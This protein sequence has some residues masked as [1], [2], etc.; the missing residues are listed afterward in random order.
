MMTPP[1]SSSENARQAP[2]RS[3]VKT[4]VWRPNIE[5]LTPAMAASR[6][7]NGKATTTGANAS[8]EQIGTANGEDPG[9]HLDRLVHPALGSSGRGRI[10][11]R[12]E[13][14][15]RIE[16]VAELQGLGA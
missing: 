12:P 9:P 10:D 4:P 2:A 14:R 13:I 11:H 8:F 6:S 1:T 16:R 3:L 7:R 15:R 5:S